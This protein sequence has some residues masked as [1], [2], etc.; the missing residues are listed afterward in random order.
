MLSKNMA[1]SFGVWQSALSVWFQNPS[2]LTL[3]S[4]SESQALITRMGDTRRVLPI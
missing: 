3:F 2:A 4:I 1:V